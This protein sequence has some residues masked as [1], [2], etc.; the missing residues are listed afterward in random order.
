MRKAFKSVLVLSLTCWI[1]L[2]P[3][4]A[5]VQELQQAW[6]FAGDYK[7]FGCLSISP[8]GS[9][10]VDLRMKSGVFRQYSGRDGRLQFNHYATLNDVWTTV[11]AGALSPDG[12]YLAM[13]FDNGSLRLID[14]VS[15][16]TLYSLKRNQAAIK[17]LA[18]KRDGSLLASS[19]DDAPLALW[20]V[21]RDSSGKTGLGEYLRIRLNQ[22]TPSF[23]EWRADGLIF[24]ASQSGGTRFNLFVADPEAVPDF[25]KNSMSFVVTGPKVDAL[26]LSP[27]GR[28]IALALW[29]LRDQGPYA[30][31]IIDIAS[32]KT[33]NELTDLEVGAQTIAFTRDGSSLLWS[34]FDGKVWRWNL[35]DGSRSTIGGAIYPISTLA[36]YPEGGSFLAGQSDGSIWRGSLEPAK[37]WELLSMSLG[38]AAYSPDGASIAFE[39]ENR[40]LVILSSAEG[41]S[42]RLLDLRD[43]IQDYDGSFL[44]LAYGPDG[45]TIALSRSDRLVYLFAADTGKKT[46]SLGPL[47]Y[48]A[49]ELAW[50]K[51][52]K[53]LFTA[54]LRDDEGSKLSAWD[55]SSGA[56]IASVA[57][58]RPVYDSKTMKRSV[59][60]GIGFDPLSGRVAE[61]CG[62]DIYI[63]NPTAGMVVKTLKEKDKGVES[64]V[65]VD[66]IPGASLLA[67]LNLTKTGSSLTLWDT[68]KWKVVRSFE[69]HT[70]Y[71]KA[72]TPSPD[73]KKLAY[74]G[75]G[76]IIQVCDLVGGTDVFKLYPPGDSIVDVAFSPDGAYLLVHCSDGSHRA[77][78]VPQDPR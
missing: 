22:P 28:S 39:A 31:R 21:A 76:G 11:T 13:G 3:S 65:D 54:N 1:A 20:L 66:F 18:F 56:R 58:P 10:F 12:R 25:V 47:E 48:P 36:L 37:P 71:A 70:A 55:V 64:I 26:A 27:D 34:G 43:E 14:T 9:F 7:D 6:A 41:R 5:E 16:K 52:G 60:V 38:Q 4:W 62:K 44:A 69:V 30:I 63:F 40:R 50:S 53:I 61:A 45:S 72:M 35:A 46:L 24:G 23:L 59:L 78:M 75:R 32:Y 2:I 51:D 68:V 33:T 77:F 49:K 74:W 29:G 57:E 67:T 73:G 8:D 15:G 19:S 42:L 17:A